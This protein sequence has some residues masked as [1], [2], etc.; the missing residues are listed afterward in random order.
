VS[1]EI[2]DH[3]RILGPVILPGAFERHLAQGLELC[4]VGDLQPSRSSRDDDGQQHAAVPSRSDAS[5]E[6]HCQD[7]EAD[8]WAQLGARCERR[9]P[10]GQAQ[11]SDASGPQI[12][13]S[14]CHGIRYTPQPS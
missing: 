9:Q 8:D 7:P 3:L 6:R 1:A 4:P 12:D 2:D 11:Q 10:H 14:R 5:Q 13:R